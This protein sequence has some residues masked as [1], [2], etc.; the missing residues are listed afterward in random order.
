ML[1]GLVLVAAGLFVAGYALDLF[2]FNL[3]FKGFW[4]LFIL[5]PSVIGLVKYGFRVSSVAGI[6]IGVLLLLSVYDI[7]SFP[8]TVKLI[9]PAL[10][11]LIGLKL[12]FRSIWIGHIVKK[13]GVGIDSLPEYCA[14]FGENKISIRE[15]F[16]GANVWSVF[17]SVVLDLRDAVIEENAVIAVYAIFGGGQVLLPPHVKLRISNIPVFGGV[18]SHFQSSPDSSASVVYL[19]SVCW[20]GGIDVR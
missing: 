20:F 19:N 5:I 10:L 6:T 9:I 14:A 8:T 11:V 13:S 12:I 2:A 17:G 4:T 7:L 18:N 15:K 16:Y 3:F 1:W